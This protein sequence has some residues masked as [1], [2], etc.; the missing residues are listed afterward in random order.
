VNS[1]GNLVHGLSLFLRFKIARFNKSVFYDPMRKVH[2][3]RKTI[4]A[5]T[6]LKKRGELDEEDS[7]I[8]FFA[9]NVRY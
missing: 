1:S 5:Y 9:I 2:F 3:I 8:I 4:I 6:N 7:N